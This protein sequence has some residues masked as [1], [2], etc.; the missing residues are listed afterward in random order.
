MK[1]H[2]FWSRVILSSYNVH[3][4]TKVDDRIWLNVC[5]CVCLFLWLQCKNPSSIIHHPWSKL[6]SLDDD[7]AE[8]RGVCRKR[9]EDFL[10]KKQPVPAPKNLEVSLLRRLKTPFEERVGFFLDGISD[11][12]FFLENSVDSLNVWRIQSLIQIIRMTTIP[13]SFHRFQKLE[14]LQLP[15][16]SNIKSMRPYSTLWD[17]DRHMYT[18][19]EYI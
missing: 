18:A 17:L 16:F 10:H 5:L 4:G 7:F 3:S 2:V 14:R 11:V 13:K 1:D 19:K 12:F 9:Q 15:V 6:P 8:V